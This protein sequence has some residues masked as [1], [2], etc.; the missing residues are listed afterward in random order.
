[1]SDILYDWYFGKITP[2]EKEITDPFVKE[3]VKKMQKTRKELEEQLPEQLK[4]LLEA[5][6]LAES[7]MH[8]RALYA[9]YLDG[10]KTGIRL[11]SAVFERD[12]AEIE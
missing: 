2:W 6:C 7:D 4:P 5:F 10:F 3:A 9:E 1:M 8:S 11:M 12:Q